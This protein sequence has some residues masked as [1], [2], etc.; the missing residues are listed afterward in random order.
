MNLN[1]IE[2]LKSLSNEQL[3]HIIA[4]QSKEIQNLEDSIVGSVLITW[5]YDIESER[6]YFYNQ[7][8]KRIISYIIYFS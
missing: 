7:N 4:K 6:L 8:P 3:V 5:T 1:K 2:D